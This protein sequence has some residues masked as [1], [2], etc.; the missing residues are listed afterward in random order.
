MY[1]TAWTDAI[2]ADGMDMVPCVCGCAP[3]GNDA[4]PAMAMRCADYRRERVKSPLLWSSINEIAYN[5]SEYYIDVSPGLAGLVVCGHTRHTYVLPYSD[6]RGLVRHFAIS[7]P[8][9][10][11]QYKIYIVMVFSV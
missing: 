7:F 1:L 10:R 3:D 8:L 4:G 11:A 2:G 5:A 6:C 9:C